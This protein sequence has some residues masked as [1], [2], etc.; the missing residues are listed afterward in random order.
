MFDNLSVT[1]LTSKLEDVVI[2]LTTVLDLQDKSSV[3]ELIEL[4][5]LRLRQQIR[6][7][8]NTLIAKGVFYPSWIEAVDELFEQYRYTIAFNRSMRDWMEGHSKVD[9]IRAFMQRHLTFF[10]RK[11]FGFVS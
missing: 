1:S 8:A 9:Y 2:E 10:P 5:G 7:A 3:K 11:C 6:R 4:N